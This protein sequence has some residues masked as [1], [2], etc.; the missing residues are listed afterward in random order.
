MNGE[1]TYTGEIAKFIDSPFGDPEITTDLI[2]ELIEKY[3]PRLKGETISYDDKSYVIC[4]AVY[5]SFIK[6]STEIGEDLNTFYHELDILYKYFLPCFDLNG[7]IINE[8]LLNELKE[9]YEEIYKKYFG[10]LLEGYNIYDIFKILQDMKNYILYIMTINGPS[11]CF[12]DFNKRILNVKYPNGAMRGV[13]LIPDW[14]NDS[15]YDYSV[16]WVNHVAD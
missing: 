7:N 8:D 6:L 9:Q 3:K 4:C 12:E 11:Y 1:D 5:K 15:D 2:L 14:P 10:G 13:V 16:L